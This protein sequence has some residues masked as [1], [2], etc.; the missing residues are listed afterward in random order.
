M[1]MQRNFA[2]LYGKY[3]WNPE[4]PTEHDILFYLNAVLIPYKITV[5][6]S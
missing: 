2:I 5:Y 3:P 4:N 6:E 1:D